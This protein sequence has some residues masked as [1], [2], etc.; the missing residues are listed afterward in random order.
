M[1]FGRKMQRTQKRNRERERERERERK[2]RQRGR[3]NDKHRRGSIQAERFSS[4]CNILTFNDI[5]SLFI[6]R[7]RFV[8]FSYKTWRLKMHL[9]VE[10]KNAQGITYPIIKIV[11]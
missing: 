2:V 9:L 6:F 1:V 3:K 11:V 7:A 4:A 8:K 10:Y 5:F